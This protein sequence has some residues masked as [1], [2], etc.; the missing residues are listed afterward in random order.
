MAILAIASNLKDLKDRLARIV[1]AMNKNGEPITADD[2]VYNLF[3]HFKKN[4]LIMVNLITLIAYF[5]SKKL[6][7]FRV[8]L[9]Q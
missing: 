9:E 7:N 5:T 2:L 8:L 1:V 3:N 6:P 4:F